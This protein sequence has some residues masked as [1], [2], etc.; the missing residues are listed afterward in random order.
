MALFDRVVELTIGVPGGDGVKITDLRVIIQAKRSHSKSPNE[1]TIRIYNCSQNTVNLLKVPGTA[2]MAAAGYVGQVA[3]FFTGDVVRHES[4]VEGPDQITTIFVKD[5]VVALRDSKI[6][7]TFKPGSSAL[8]ALKAIAGSFGLPIRQNLDITDVVLPRGLA[9][10]GRVRNAMDEICQ[11]LGLEWSAQGSE[12]Q[13]IKKGGVYSDQAVLLSASTG[14]IGSPKPEAKQMTDKAAAKKGIKYGQD[15]VRRYTKTDP[16]AKIKE[17]QMYDVEGYNVESLFNS[18]I[19]PG[20]VVVLEARGI[21]NKT[22]RV[23]EC[24]YSLDSHG[25]DFKVSAKLRFPSEVKQ[26]G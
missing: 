15:G 6:N 1:A 18:A 17:R 13:I 21:D 7:L 25:D 3:V 2:V 12:I 8:D 9:F 26:N 16:T 20:A 10:N 24:T 23:E 14:L 19:Y 11:F 22:F 4:S 5:S